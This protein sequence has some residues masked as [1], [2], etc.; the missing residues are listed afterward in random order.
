[1]HRATVVRVS[2]DGVWC[3]VPAL[4]PSYELGPFQCGPLALVAGDRVLVCQVSPSN[5]HDLVVVGLLRQT[6]GSPVVDRYRAATST[7]STTVDLGAGTVQL[8]TLGVANTTIA[9][10]GATSG[11][12]ASISLYLKQDATGA[13][14]V[15]WPASVKWPGGIAPTLSAGA[16]EVDLVTLETLDGGTVW[17][18]TLAGADFQ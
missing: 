2:A 14:L 1:M 5:P 18:A 6:A 9:L 3:Q 12:P 16:N 7:A 8:L 10:T 11:I 13:R 4:G 17:Y 15:T